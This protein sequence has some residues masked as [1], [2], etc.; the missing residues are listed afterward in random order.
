M[1][2]GSKRKSMEGE[3]DRRRT[4]NVKGQ[5]R[6]G[7]I[8]E[9]SASND[10]RRNHTHTNARSFRFDPLA[11]WSGDDCSAD[12]APAAFLHARGG[13]HCKFAIVLRAG[14]S[15][16]LVTLIVEMFAVS[17]LCPSV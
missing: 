12:T 17:D 13:R 15:W 4:R 10:V 14:F 3:S 16:L 2:S 6:Y 1:V 7:A 11:R 5:P 8:G 9:R